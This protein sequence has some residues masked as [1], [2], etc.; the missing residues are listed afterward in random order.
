[1]SG[2]HPFGVIVLSPEVQQLACEVGHSPASSGEAEMSG[3]MLLL[4]LCTFMAW[5]GPTL[6]LL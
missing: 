6:P 2:A 4:P 5:T 1:M 3:A